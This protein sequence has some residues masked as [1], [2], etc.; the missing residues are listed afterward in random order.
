LNARIRQSVVSKRIRGRTVIV[1]A[2][3][4]GGLVLPA[5]AQAHGRSN[6]IA[7]DYEARVAANVQR[8]ARVR[9]RVIDGDRKLELAVAPVHT[10]VVR[11]Y[12]GEPF[13]RFSARGVEVNDGSPTAVTDRLAPRGAVPSLSRTARPRWSLLTH[14]H[15]L[16]WHDHRLGPRP[17]VRRGVG[18]VADWSIPIVVDG[19]SQQIDGEL[20]RAE[21]PS[22][23]PWLAL[24]LGALAAAFIVALRAPRRLRRGTVYAASAVCGLLVFVVSAGFAFVSGRSVTT[25]W[26]GLSVPALIALAAGGVLFL[27]PRRRQVAAAVAGGFAFAAAL[28]DL[29]VFRHGFVVSVLPAGIVRLVVALAITAGAIAVIVALIELWRGESRRSH[30]SRPRPQPRL[31]IPRSKAR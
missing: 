3:A 6:V 21:T 18:H 29:S 30:R 9:A 19:F 23:W 4:I 27:Q 15:R 7:L 25:S 28:E 10:V 2:A 12:S 5:Q 1:I 13:L 11:G 20:W 26:I 17:G 24:W 8:V 31:A 22:L 16:A 14:G